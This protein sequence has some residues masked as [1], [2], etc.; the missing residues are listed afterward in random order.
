MIQGRGN[1]DLAI[2]EPLTRA[3]MVT[4]PVR[5]GP[6]GERRHCRRQ[7]DQGFTIGL[8][9]GRFAPDEPLTEAEALAF[10][11][12]LTG[13]EAVEEGWPDAYIRGAAQAGPL[14]DGESIGAERATRGEAF[15]LVD[16]GMAQ[17]K[18]RARVVTEVELPRQGMTLEAHESGPISHTVASAKHLNLAPL[19][20]R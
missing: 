3:E 8:P 15:V 6:L 4:T 16:R 17:Q 13:T 14:T 20:D 1:G 10:V 19:A 2:S 7:D 5:A 11:M 9:D 18:P 12:K